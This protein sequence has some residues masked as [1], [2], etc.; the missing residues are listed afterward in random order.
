MLQHKGGLVYG[1]KAKVDAVVSI[2]AKPF[3][4][5]AMTGGARPM[6]K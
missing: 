4:G 2:F 1:I 6:E 3:R 5:L